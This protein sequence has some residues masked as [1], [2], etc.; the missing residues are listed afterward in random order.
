M[1]GELEDRLPNGLFAS[2]SRMSMVLDS[3]L[4]QRFYASLRGD[5]A[6]RDSLNQPNVSSTILKA[7]GEHESQLILKVMSQ[8]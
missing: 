5:T 7:D 3:V 8:E 4:R 1:L 6:L 2:T